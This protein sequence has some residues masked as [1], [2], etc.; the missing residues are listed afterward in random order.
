ML[1]KFVFPIHY[2]ALNWVVDDALRQHNT[3][4][5]MIYSKNIEFWIGSIEFLQ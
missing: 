5:D 1:N 4:Y 2:A 3:G